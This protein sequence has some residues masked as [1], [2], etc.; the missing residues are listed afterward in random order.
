[1][2]RK[3]YIEKE[4]F[5]SSEYKKTEIEVYSTEKSRTIQSA[6]SLTFGMFKNHNEQKL[7]KV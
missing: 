7:P 5:L 6:E 3:E 2:L 4:R 1:M